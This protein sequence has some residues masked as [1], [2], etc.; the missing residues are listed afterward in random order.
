[1]SIIILDLSI[2][3]L[4]LSII[5]LDLSIIV[6]NRS[7]ISADRSKI[8]RGRPKTV[9]DTESRLFQNQPGFET[10]PKEYYMS[11]S[12]RDPPNDAKFDIWFKNLVDYVT[13]KCNPPDAP[14]WSFIPYSEVTLLR[15][16]YTDWRAA[17]TPT[18]KPHTPEETL[19]K[20]EGREA[21][22]PYRDKGSARR[23]KPKDV[24]GI[25]VCWAILDH[26]PASIKE[27]INSAFDTE[28]PL[29]LE[30]GEEDRGKRVYLVGRWEIERE[31][32]KGDFGEIVP[33]V[34]P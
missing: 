24:H 33:A 27:L 19:A 34:I 20:D 29:I 8:I 14:E 21:A 25:E 1:L 28:S 32:V 9:P 6:L 4:D 13:A 11:G 31:G 5:V 16:A 30:F 22:V 18:L 12:S 10:T 17:Y 26:P 3:I 15:N 7:K 23:G 2:I